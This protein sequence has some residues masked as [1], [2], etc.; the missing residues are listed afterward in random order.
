METRVVVVL[1]L[2]PL[3]MACGGSGDGNDGNSQDDILHLRELDM[4]EAD[5]KRGLLEDFEAV[6]G[7]REF[8][9]SITSQG[10]EAFVDSLVLGD[11]T[12]DRQGDTR[13]PYP[14]QTPKPGQKAERAS[15]ERLYAIAKEVCAR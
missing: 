12:L 6:P 15:Q 14:Y 8:L 7:L 10:K 5:A 11:E 4:S 13:T 3:L 9:C 2:L 1:T